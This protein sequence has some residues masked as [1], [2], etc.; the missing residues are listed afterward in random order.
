[1]IPLLTSWLWSSRLGPEPEAAAGAAPH[2]LGGRRGV[3]SRPFCTDGELIRARGPQR[4]T[5][6]ASTLQ[7]AAPASR[8]PSSE[9]T[10]PRTAEQGRGSSFLRRT[11]RELRFQTSR[12]RCPESLPENASYGPPPPR[13]LFVS[14]A[15]FSRHQTL[16]NTGWRLKRV[17]NRNSRTKTA[18]CLDHCKRSTIKTL[19]ALKEKVKQ[20]K[21][22]KLKISN[23]T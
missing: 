6:R 19:H 9:T 4:Q 16:G 23:G 20:R 8:L 13:L 15:A 22:F 7:E 2:G 21:L 12:Q 5:P 11:S 14:G 1:M 18:Y 3:W 17:V 10:L